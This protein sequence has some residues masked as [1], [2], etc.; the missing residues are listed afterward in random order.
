MKRDIQLRLQMDDSAPGGYCN[1]L[2]A[3]AGAEFGE[4]VFE[5]N[6]DGLLRDGQLRCD[7]L[8]SV[9]LGEQA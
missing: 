9:A 3:I 8:I 7:I 5:M 6:L 1:R 4:D 2:S